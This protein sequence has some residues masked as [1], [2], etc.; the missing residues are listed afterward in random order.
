MKIIDYIFYRL[1]KV[2]QKHNDPPTFSA[3]IVFAAIGMITLIF[4]SIFFNTVL[5]NEYFSIENFTYLEG[6]VI[7]IGFGVL[8]II[9]CYLRYTKKK[10][11]EITKRFKHSPWNKMIPN[12]IIVSLP[13]SELL[14]GVLICYFI[15][16]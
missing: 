10:M 6:A 15:F 5:T 2:Y 9:A 8:I 1:Y 12:W 14:V 11:Q 4:F 7:F 16:K 13:I 3:G